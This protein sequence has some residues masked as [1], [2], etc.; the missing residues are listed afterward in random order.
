MVADRIIPDLK[1]YMRISAERG[2]SLRCPFATVERCPRY[3]QSLSLLGEAGST[4]IDKLEDERLCKKW[5]RSDLWPRTA[6][7]ATAITS[8]TD[9]RGNKRLLSFSNFCPEVAYDRF[10]YFA[11]YLHRYAD[12][13]DMDM[14]H[15]WLAEQAAPPKD[16]RWNWAT[17]QAM[18]YAE[19]PLYSPSCMLGHPLL[20]RMV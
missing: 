7:Y 5:K 3:Y 17:V 20:S 13:I 15:K 1:W 9:E 11:A 8:S 19:C 4:K 6:E 16:W 2:L 12:E 14:S 18:H 10:G